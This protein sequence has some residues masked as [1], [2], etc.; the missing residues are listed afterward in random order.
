MALTELS[1]GDRT[2]LDRRLKG[3]LRALDP[4][5][6]PRLSAHVQSALSDVNRDGK[7]D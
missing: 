2:G 1:V 3:V 5:R 4:A 7:G 6:S